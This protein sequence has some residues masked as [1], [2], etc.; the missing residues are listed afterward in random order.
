ME[1]KS[2]L[3]VG[4]RVS[5]V[6]KEVLGMTQKELASAL[7]IWSF[8]VIGRWERGERPL[9][10]KRAEQ[11]EAM[12]AERAEEEYKKAIAEGRH[13]LPDGPAK[14]PHVTAEYLLGYVEYPSKA[15]ESLADSFRTLSRFLTVEEFLTSYAYTLGYSIEP[16][17]ES[18]EEYPEGFYELKKGEELVR[19][20]TQ[21]ELLEISRRIERYAR[22]EI[23]HLAG[24]F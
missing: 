9:P 13:W 17:I 4:Q 20:I 16:Q 12:T 21:N 14:H 1:E 24:E 15:V 8:E 23:L 22:M 6:R 3:S 11:L 7:G 10:P 18:T 2:T 19:R 5:W